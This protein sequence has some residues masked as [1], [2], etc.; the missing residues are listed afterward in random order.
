VTLESATITFTQ[1]RREFAVPANRVTGAFYGNKAHEHINTAAAA[2]LMLV[3]P[4]A[5]LF[6]RKGHDRI[7]GLT[8]TEPETNKQG[9]VILKVPTDN[10][11]RTMLAVLSAA[12]GK[13]AVNTDS[14]SGGK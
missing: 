14:A 3:S 9:G 6:L 12:T 1:E 2:G 8:W 4:L 5:I 7:I 13:T 10:E 11:Y